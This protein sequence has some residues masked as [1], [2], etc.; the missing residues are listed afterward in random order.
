L[1]TLTG[2]NN[3]VHEI[4]GFWRSIGLLAEVS[5]L[6]RDSA[7]AQ[8]PYQEVLRLIRKIVPFDAATLFTY[9][10]KRK[11]FDAKTSLDGR[12]NMLNFVSTGNGGSK[13]SWSIPEKKPALISPVSYPGLPE[14]V[15]EYESL[16]SAP[17]LSGDE[18]IGV[19]NLGCRRSGAF[20]ENDVRLITVVTDL[21]S[22]ATERLFFREREALM[23]QTLNRVA[24]GNNSSKDTVEMSDRLAVAADLVASVHHQINN[25]L[26]VIVGN[27]QCLLIEKKALDQKALDRLKLIEKA[28]LK[29][30]KVNRSL[31]TVGNLAREPIGAGQSPAEAALVEEGKGIG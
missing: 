15:G 11:R 22:A 16:M 13:L 26:A 25:P 18:V 8:P 29:V 31:L 5:A 7:S 1:D 17:M 10:H 9:N 23:R 4:S 3:G 24:A 21:F 28:A 12:L 6:C 19:L 27:V 20:D 14:S 2:T 30:S